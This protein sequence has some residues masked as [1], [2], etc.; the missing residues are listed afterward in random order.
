MVTARW[1]WRRWVIR[2]RGRRRRIVVARGRILS[3]GR[4]LVVP[5]WWRR[6]RRISGTVVDWALD[7]TLAV[8]VSVSLTLP[9]SLVGRRNSQM[10]SC[11]MAH[12]VTSYE[13]IYLLRSGG[14]EGDREGSRRKKR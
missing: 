9:E 5:G 6:W 14:K 7:T 8:L 10:T 1:W 11:E 13:G 2:R 4:S 3:W 12:L